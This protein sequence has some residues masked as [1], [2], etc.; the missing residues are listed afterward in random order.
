LDDM[1]DVFVGRPGASPVATV[2]GPKLANGSVRVAPL[3]VP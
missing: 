1:S 3:T 2:K